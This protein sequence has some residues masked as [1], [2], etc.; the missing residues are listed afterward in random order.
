MVKSIFTTL[1]AFKEWVERLQTQN[2]LSK[3]AF[4][5]ELD[6]GL[7]WDKMKLN[8]L[9]V[10]N[11]E[12]ACYFDISNLELSSVS[13]YLRQLFLSFEK[14][15][16]HN[17]PYDL[18]V[19][20]R[21]NIVSPKEIT[22]KIFD[23]MT[24]AH[25]IDENGPKGLKDL[26]LVHGIAK[27]NEVK[28]WKQ[29]SKYSTSSKE[30]YDYAINDAIW[31]WQLHEIFGV[32]LKQQN[33]LDLFFTIE[34]PFQF[35]LVEMESNGIT[36]D[37]EKI[38]E[39]RKRMFALKIEY[40]SKM[41]KLLG[42]QHTIQQTLFGDSEYISPVNFN[43]SPQLIKIIEGFG[44]TLPFL[45]KTEQKSVDKATL[46]Y[47]SGQ[48]LF[49]DLLKDYRTVEKLL[50]GF[51]DKLPNHI[52]LD[53]RIR[54]SFNNTG[55]ATGRLSSND[56]NMQQLPKNKKSVGANIRECFIA[57]PGK[58]IIV[59]DYSGQELRVLTEVTQDSNLI[60]CFLKGGDIHLATTNKVLKLGIPNEALF[61]SHKDYESYKLK[62]KTER[63]SIKN[64]V[65]FPIVYG[66]TAIGVSK[67]LG[68]SETKAQN[69]I[70]GFFELYPRVKK[71][72]F[73]TVK[74]VKT[75]NYVKNLV[76]R[77][78]RF[79]EITGYAFRQAFNFK[80]QGFSADMIRLA[81]ILILGEII[82][83]PEWGMDFLLIVHDEVV[84]EANEQ[85]A[86]EAKKLIKHCMETAV[87][88]C[89]PVVAD[90]GVGFNYADGKP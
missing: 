31:T 66:T 30:F 90:V 46:L 10:C 57:S 26:V 15:I 87:K 18:K 72:W 20:N 53:G 14:L 28:T 8:G 52:C 65:V 27:N 33:L 83:H 58:K 55:T 54:A 81:S 49:I 67:S 23:T 42:L 85:F 63:D 22:H 4:D 84:L 73:D 5:T 12:E 60:K 38:Q 17:I 35:V 47:L 9:S 21:F 37:L 76:G 61:D 82:K 75:Y 86:E 7:V 77:K 56:P 1:S 25:L 48:H 29:I 45:T 79:T 78:R 88:F 70:D 6:D 51:L 80:V 40:E 39:L 32:K 24:A 36:L 13:I 41:L 2:K 50:N 74:Q 69:Y 89:I 43:S 11:G 34:M 19:L 62:F 71:V 64:K 3:V 68:I 16:A 44:L 59:G